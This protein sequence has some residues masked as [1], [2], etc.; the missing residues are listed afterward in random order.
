MI[1][2]SL[3]EPIPSPV[4]APGDPFGNPVSRWIAYHPTAI[5]LLIFCA[6]MLPG[7]IGHDP[8]KPDEGY[9]FGLVN[10][11]LRTGDWVVPTLTGEPFMEKP[12]IFYLVAALFAKIAS[13]LLAPH[14]GARLACALFVGLAALFTARAS[15]VLLP[16]RPV[17]VAPLLLIGSLGLM[18][19]AHQLV[20]DNALLCGFA[21]AIYGFA[22]ALRRPLAGGFWLGTGTGLGFMA[23]GLLAPGIIGITA[24]LL[25]VCFAQWRTR[26]YLAVLCI[27][28]LAAAPWFFIW[29]VALYLRSPQ[30]FIDW[31]WT[32]N[33]GRFF[34]FA[35]LGPPAEP[36]AYLKLLVWFA[37]PSLPFAVRALWIR[38]REL[39]TD[40]GLQIATTV[41]AVMFTVLSAAA[42]ARE[43]YAM[44]L[45]MPLALLGVSGLE[46]LPPV[47]TRTFHWLTA[48]LFTGIAFAVWACWF[49][50]NLGFPAQLSAL[51]QQ[52]QPLYLPHV[53]VWLLC[54]AIAL[55]VAW[56]TLITSRT[57]PYRPAMIWAAGVATAWGLLGTLMVSWYDTGMTYRGMLHELARALPAGH[58]CIASRSLGESQRAI[59]EYF[60]GIVTE[61]Q[62]NASARNDCGLLLVQTLELPRAPSPGEPWALIW[63]G[64]RPGDRHEHFWLY[65]KTP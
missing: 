28:F 47:V 38:R 4:E 15:S 56:L 18:I 31:F 62:A 8:W 10:H 35:H 34:G 52:K 60:S 14:D 17:W 26:H 57:G 42:D 39:R 61:R 36:Y 9:T 53:R 11:I 29:P 45:L 7:L 21:M 16:L 2:T 37:L 22:L 55:S 48:S 5:A 59:F 46:N 20:T 65:R 23:K 24:L 64:S 25:P 44:P 6:W 49:A 32:N 27:T 12:P 19:H 54:I 3:P 51:L 58:G 43:L 13:P 41:F 40:A 33:F 1:R 50:V 63:D 30:L